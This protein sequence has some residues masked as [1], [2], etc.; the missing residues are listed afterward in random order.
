MKALFLLLFLTSN[1]LIFGQAI[2]NKPPIA[3]RIPF[4]AK[5]GDKL[6]VAIHPGVELLSIIQY[7]SGNQGPMSSTYRTDVREHFGRYRTHPAVM[8]LF[9]SNARFGYDLP[10]LGWCFTDPLH[11]TSFT[12]PEETYWYKSF[13]KAELT[14]YLSLCMD[15]AKKT[16]F[17]EFYE[18]HRSQYDQWGQVF[19]HRV[20]SL[21]IIS[22]LE[23]FYQRPVAS[24]WYICLDPLNGGGA[25]AI[26]TQTL[27]PAYSDYIVYQQGYWNR[28]ASLTTIPAFQ[29]D[30]Y[31]LVW[32]EGSHVVIN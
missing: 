29:A 18:R 22:K 23:T 8:F 25:H 27:A 15:F 11:P 12:L 6:T 14:T 17:A 1:L 30:M 20:D 10:E 19:Q 32:H 31:N 21:Q 28:Q 3:K 9:N 24:K 16:N 4:G 2:P 7:L 13:A 5:P 26:M